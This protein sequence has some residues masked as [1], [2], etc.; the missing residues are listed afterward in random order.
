MAVYTVTRTQVWAEVEADD[1]E[2][3]REYAG[4][5]SPDASDVEVDETS[6]TEC[7][8]EGRVYCPTC[9]GTGIGQGGDPDTSRCDHCNGRG[10][11]PCSECT[12][13]RGY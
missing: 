13:E 11:T 4:A 7:H 8:G 3:A 1:E 6:C 12:Q 2:G 5:H 9:Q 10:A